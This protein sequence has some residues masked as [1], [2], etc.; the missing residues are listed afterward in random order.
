MDVLLPYWEQ[1]FMF[2]DASVESRDATTAGRNV[3]AQ[4][5]VSTRNRKPHTW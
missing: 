5:D 4:Q 2:G 1:C 3:N